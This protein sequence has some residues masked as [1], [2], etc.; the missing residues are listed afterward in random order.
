M[1]S[2]KNPKNKLSQPYLF[3]KSFS[4]KIIQAKSSKNLNSSLGANE[5]KITFKQN[6]SRQ[7]SRFDFVKYDKVREPA[8]KE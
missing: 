2:P 5:T 6:D 4:P 7:Y 1:Q 8:E 3:E